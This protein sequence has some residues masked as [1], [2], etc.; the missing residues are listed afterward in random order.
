MT[1]IGFTWFFQGLQVVEQRGRLRDRGDRQ[2]RSPTRSSS[3][4]WSASRPGG[5]DPLPAGRRRRRLP[6]DDPPA[7]DLGTVHR[8]DQ[9][10]RLRRMPGKPDLDL[11]ARRDRQHAQRLSVRD[12]PVRGHGGGGDRLSAAGAHPRRRS[13]GSSAPVVAT[14]GLAFSILLTQLVLGETRRRRTG[15][16]TSPSPARS[17]SSPASPSPSSLGL[18]RSRIGRAEEIR[19]ALTR[20]ERAAHR[21][22]ARQG[23]GAA[24]VAHADRRGRLRRAPPGRARPPRRRPAAAGGAGD[25]PAARPRQDRR[26]PRRRR[27]AARRGDGGARRGDARSCASWP[28][29]S[30]R[31]CSATAA[32]RRR[33]AASPTARR[34]RSRSSRRRR[35]RLPARSSRRPTS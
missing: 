19:T 18:L 15:A 21:R 30:T 5:S 13:D 25:E 22:A 10:E 26:R 16:K 7:A 34:S 20:R 28:A 12:R 27:R 11:R 14:G 17:P 3:S 4:C 29:A 24:R 2:R 8:P 23:R 33:S 35:E 32:S 1:A 31:P 6:D 9:A